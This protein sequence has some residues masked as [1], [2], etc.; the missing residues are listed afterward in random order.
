MSKR[1][2][3]FSMPEE[4][5][6]KHVPEDFNEYVKQIYPYLRKYVEIKSKLGEDD[7]S[8][9]ISN[10]IIFLMEQNNEGMPRWKRFDNTEYPHYS[11]SAW[12]VTQSKYFVQKKIYSRTTMD[13]STRTPSYTIEDLEAVCTNIPKQFTEKYMPGNIV[14]YN[15]ILTTIESKIQGMGNDRGR[16]LKLD[17]LEIYNLYF[18]EDCTLKEIAVLKGVGINTIRRMILSVKDLIK[19]ELEKELIPC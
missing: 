1:T 5:L 7:V 14:D 10:Y 2:W 8:E 19:S 18:K 13:I 16:G 3:A 9:I 6:I 17:F 4:L 15:N 11:Y 12:F